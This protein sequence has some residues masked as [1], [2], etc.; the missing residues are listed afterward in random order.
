ML[1][2]TV[3]L[4]PPAMLCQ[5]GF[6]PGNCMLPCE[7][8]RL[9]MNFQ[10]ISYNAR[11]HGKL[12]LLVLRAFLA[13]PALLLLRPQSHLSRS[14]SRKQGHGPMPRYN[15]D[16]DPGN[17][18]E[19]IVGTRH[20]VE[21][22]AMR[23][24]SVFATFCSQVLQ[25]Q[26]GVQ[27]GE[28]GCGVD[29]NGR[30]V[31]ERVDLGRG[32][33]GRRVDKIG[34]EDAGEEPVVSGVF[35]NVEC[36]HSAIAEAVDEEGLELALDEVQRN[37]QARERLQGGGFGGGVG[38][39]VWSEEVEERVDQKRPNVLDHEDGAPRDLEAFVWGEYAFYVSHTLHRLAYLDL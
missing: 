31:D 15:C 30:V 29:C 5:T 37:Q 25:Y 4:R 22:P 2:F 13:V 19:Q 23:H 32:R 17:G 10:S 3:L 38:V 11:N 14:Y 28:L 16:T 9:A 36:W 12:L 34:G 33:G 27:V 18:L 21:T 26:V 35:E 20:Q 8:S 7:C 39:D 6:L 24:A 1:T